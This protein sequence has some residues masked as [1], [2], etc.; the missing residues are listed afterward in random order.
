MAAWRAAGVGF[1]AG[2]GTASVKGL[3]GMRRPRARQKR[4][5]PGRAFTLRAH[6]SSVTIDGLICCK[7]SRAS[8]IIPAISLCLVELGVK[9]ERA[10]DGFNQ[11][12]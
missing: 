8:A 4:K 6:K 11:V 12:D 9:F 3:T 5:A 10:E 7:P 2:G 1:L